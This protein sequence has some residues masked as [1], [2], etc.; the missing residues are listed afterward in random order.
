MPTK[1]PSLKTLENKENTLSHRYEDAV[2]EL[3]KTNRYTMWVGDFGKKQ[4]DLREQLDKV[5]AQLQKINNR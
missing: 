4:V 5:R 3:A 2:Q 1:A